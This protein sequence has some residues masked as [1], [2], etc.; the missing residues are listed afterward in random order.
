MEQNKHLSGRVGNN[1]AV[2]A[3]D[4]EHK[5]TNSDFSIRFVTINDLKIATFRLLER[6][7]LINMPEALGRLGV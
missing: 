4:E 5:N 3:F 2:G 1:G 7:V 6:N